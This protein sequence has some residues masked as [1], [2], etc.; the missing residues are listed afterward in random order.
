[1][2]RPFLAYGIPFAAGALRVAADG[3][4]PFAPQAPGSPP[5]ATRLISSTRASDGSEGA[6]SSW[7]KSG[8]APRR[9]RRLADKARRLRILSIFEGGATQDAR[10]YRSSNA[11]GLSPRA[12][13][14]RSRSSRGVDRRPPDDCASP[15]RSSRLS[16]TRT[17]QKDE[18]GSPR[19][20]GLVIR[21][22]RHPESGLRRSGC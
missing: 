9:T 20:R 15:D 13:S 8:V 3:A 19:V 10:M 21:C 12:A 4:A 6:S 1:M 7:W 11:G 2:W 5:R 22:R 16:R 14:T 17:F 18:A